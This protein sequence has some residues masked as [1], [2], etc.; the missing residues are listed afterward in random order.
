MKY[1]TGQEIVK[2]KLIIKIRNGK[3]YHSFVKYKNLNEG[4]IIFDGIELNII[5]NGELEI[6]YVYKL[7]E[8]I[9][10]RY[11]QS[12]REYK[13]NN[14]LPQEIRDSKIKQILKK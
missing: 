14:I 2:R 7:D 4:D 10:Q 6:L 3:P 12:I 5:V 9:K 13:I 11:L 8:I 1:K